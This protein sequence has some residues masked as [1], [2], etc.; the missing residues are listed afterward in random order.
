MR[1]VRTRIPTFVARWF[2]SVRALVLEAKSKRHSQVVVFSLQPIEPGSLVGSLEMRLCFFGQVEEVTYVAR[3]SICFVSDLPDS[4][5]GVLSNSLK[6][7]IPRVPVTLFVYDQRF[8][9]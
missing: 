6:H 1:S 8:V 2:F 3:A 9:C 5:A 4:I 7:T